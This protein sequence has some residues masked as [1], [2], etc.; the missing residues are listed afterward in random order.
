MN[1]KKGNPTDKEIAALNRKHNEGTSTFEE[2]VLFYMAM[3]SDELTARN[4]AAWDHRLTK[5]DV[6]PPSDEEPLL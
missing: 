1:A 5:G 6:N 3:G 2:D 4:Q